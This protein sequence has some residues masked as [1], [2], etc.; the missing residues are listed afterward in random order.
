MKTTLIET[1]TICAAGKFGEQT[2]ERQKIMLG[3]LNRAASGKTLAAPDSVRIARE[4]LDAL[5]VKPK[6]E[7]TGTPLERSRAALIERHKRLLMEEMRGAADIV[8]SD[9]KHAMGM[10]SV[11]NPGPYRLAAA[12]A[13]IEAGEAVLIRDEEMQITRGRK[14]AEGKRRQR[15][16]VVIG[17]PGAEMYAGGSAEEAI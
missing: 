1:F 5:G 8:G 12:E 9:R 14:P 3:L 2:R 10:V 15:R 13:L 6:A 7:R 16:V 4:T 17:L 11:V